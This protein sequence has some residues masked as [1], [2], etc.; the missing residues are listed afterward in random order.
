MNWKPWSIV[1]AGA[2]ASSQ[3]GFT[4]V[5]LLLATA[6]AA[7]LLVG[8]GSITGQALDTHDTARGAN[9]LTRQAQFAM[10]RMRQALA[11]TRLLLLPLIWGFI[12]LPPDEPVAPGES[13]VPLPGWSEAE[14]RASRFFWLSTLAY[15]LLMGAQV[16]G[17][18]H[19]FNRVAELTDRDVAATA[20]QVLALASWPA[21][22]VA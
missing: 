1:E 5:E 9:E 10:Q 15:F 3:R 20:V 17:I 4:L 6:M 2:S 22:M 18:A 7:L 19:L 12:R 13:A 8:L 14:A 11:N 16:G 21:S